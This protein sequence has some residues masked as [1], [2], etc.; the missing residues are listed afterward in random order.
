MIKN[1]VISGTHLTLKAFIY[2]LV[3]VMFLLIVTANTP[4]LFGIRSYVVQTGSMEPEIPVGSIILSIPQ[5]TYQLGDVVLFKDDESR[6]VAHRVSQSIIKDGQIF[7]Q[8]KG[9][10]NNALDSKL[11]AGS[12]ISGKQFFSIPS[13]GKISAFI[14]TIPG[15]LVVLGIPTILFI[16]FELKNIKNELEKDLE[17]K[18]KEQMNIAV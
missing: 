9:D 17:K 2:T 12:M 1:K 11:A 16:G 3:P 14:K 10:A 7:Y 18:I 5:K 8:T 13:V 4:I 6:I 15:F